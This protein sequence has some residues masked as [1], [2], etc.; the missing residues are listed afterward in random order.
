LPAVCHGRA[1]S[2]ATTTSDPA[3]NPLAGRAGQKLRLFGAL[4]RVELSHA[5]PQP[6]VLRRRIDN[7][8]SHKAAG[9]SPMPWFDDEVRQRLGNGINDHS[10]QMPANAVAA[11]DFAS[12]GENRGSV[13]EEP[14]LR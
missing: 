9:L 5:A 8:D 7:I 2:K 14:A 6:E 4:K 11:H 3:R 10:S 13:H 1:R 12:N